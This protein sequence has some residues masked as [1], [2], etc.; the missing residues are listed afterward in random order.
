MRLR[1]RQVALVAEDLEPVERAITDELGI[2][3]CYRDPGVA[4][5]GL[6][7]ALFPIGDKLLEV[8]APTTDGTTAG[9]L[10]EKRRGDGGYMVILETDVLDEWKQRFADHDVRVVYTAKG[11]GITGLHL[12]PRDVG[13]AILSVDTTDTWGEWPWAGPAWRDHVRTDRVTDLTG[14]EIQADE[15]A[16]MAARWSAILGRPAVNIDDGG[17][18]L[19]LDEGVIRFVPATDGRGDGLS[20]LSVAAAPGEAPRRVEIGG[21]RI[22]IAGVA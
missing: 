5:F 15:P 1:L 11:P 7:N 18:E 13:G 22:D 3:L 8:V 2:E 20:G 9:R 14:V 19:A 21:V 6:H 17:S 16:A 12:H 4:E 10:L